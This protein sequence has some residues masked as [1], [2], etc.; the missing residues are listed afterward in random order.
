VLHSW[1]QAHHAQSLPLASWTIQ[2]VGIA[3]CKITQ[4][5]QDINLEMEVEVFFWADN[6]C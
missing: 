1:H 5:N 4:I 6:R 2:A 3:I